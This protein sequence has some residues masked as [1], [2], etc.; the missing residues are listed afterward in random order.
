MP[1][2]R[3][4]RVAP[5]LTAVVRSIA[6]RQALSTAVPAAC[7][8]VWS[9]MRAAQLPKPGRNVALYLDGRI[10][11]E[12]GAEVAAPFPAS[13]RVIC[14]Q[15]PGGMVATATHVGPYNQLAA[16]H[17]A[18]LAWCA[19]HGKTLAGPNW[20]VYGHW[21]DDPSQLRTDVFYLLVPEGGCPQPPP[22]P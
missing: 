9:Y 19:A 10:T 8:E 18:I 12:A 17:S 14:S 21:T 5:Q 15:T 3:L 20:E 16:A 11:F 4:T 22:A 7:G 2:V 6:P 1:E 13:D